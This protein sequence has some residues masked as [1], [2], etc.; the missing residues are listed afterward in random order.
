ML[1]A[2][3]IGE[4]ATQDGQEPTLL[5]MTFELRAVDAKDAA[6]QRS[7]EEFFF[8]FFFYPKKLQM[9]NPTQGYPSDY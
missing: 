1:E 8:F 6:M 4:G 7:A 5:G 9:Q 2:G 3:F